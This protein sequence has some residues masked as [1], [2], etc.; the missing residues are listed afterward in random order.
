MRLVSFEVQTAL[1]RFTRIG[2]LVGDTIVDLSS[3]YLAY[4]VDEERLDV[5]QARALAEALV[6]PDMI[7][8]LEGGARSRQAAE[9][10]L[11]YLGERLKHTSQ[12]SGPT[13]ERLTFAEAEIRWL[14]PVPR[15]PMIRDGILLLDHYRAGMQRLLDLDEGWMPDE[16]RRIPI[17]WKPSRAA[18]AG[19]QEP[20]R[21]PRYSERLDY[22]FELG[23]YISQRGKDI[24]LDQAKQYIAGYTIFND[25]GCRDVQPAELRLRLGPTKSKDFETSKI[26]GPCLVTA[27]ELSNV[28]GLRMQVRVNGEVWFEGSFSNFAFSFEELIAHVSRDETL[29]PGDFFG[30]GPPAGSAGFELGRWIKPG[31]LVECWIQGIGVLSNRIIRQ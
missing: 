29:E 17:Y 6:P 26:M 15:P 13:G 27:D 4:L 11:A 10:A 23:M 14:A 5:R 2:S 31:D 12:P 22:E 9:Y 8:F 28:D 30:S 16:A 20:V 1:G 19:H 3:T 25:L 24:P 18:V 21:W 7:G